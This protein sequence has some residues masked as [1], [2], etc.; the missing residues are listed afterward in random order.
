ME[1]STSPAVDGRS[2]SRSGAPW[3][4]AAPWRPL[5]W[6]DVYSVGDPLLDDDHRRLMEE[7]NHLG[8]ALINQIAPV[9][10]ALIAPLKR[11]AHQE[12][13]H[14][15]REEAILAQLGYPG[16]E[17]HRAEHR[18]LE[19]GLGALVESLIPQGPIEPEILADLLKDWF[20]RHVLGQDMR[21]KTY[22]LEGRERA[23]PPRPP[24]AQP[25]T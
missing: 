24:L 6:L 7:I 8:A 25:K 22:V 16:L 10:E 11:L 18:Q 2:A 4:G 17:D 15:L 1:K 3:T 21:Y 19:S 23:A 14:N 5:I 13:E 20:V 12:A 9:S